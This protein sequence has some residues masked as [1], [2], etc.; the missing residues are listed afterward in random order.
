MYLGDASHGYTPDLFKNQF[1]AAAE[2]VKR[3]VIFSLHFDCF[4]KLIE[5]LAENCEKT[6][7]VLDIELSKQVTDESIQDI[8]KF[9]QLVEMNIFSCGFSSEGQSELLLRKNFIS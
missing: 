7:K 4:N 6:L 8:V 2:V 9:Q 1:L 5:L 3:L